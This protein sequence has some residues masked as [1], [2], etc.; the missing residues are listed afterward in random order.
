MRPLLLALP[1]ALLPL[2]LAQAHQHAH[3]HDHTHAHNHEH[4]SLGTHEH[5]TAELNVVLDGQTLEI[6]L[7]SP[8]MNLLGFEHAAKSA[9][10]RA[11]VSALQHQLQAPQTLL[12]LS[13][14][15]CSL[16][17]HTLESPLLAAEQ[18][19]NPHDQKHQHGDAEAAH[20]HDVEHSDI[21]AHYQFD[22]QQPDALKQLDLSELFKAFP[23]MEKIQVQLIGPAGQQ[24][25]ELGQGKTT[26]SF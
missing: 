18:A 14:G 13:S 20:D 2:T 16:V 21:H 25:L 3:K 23:G 17:S 26:L 15:D 1:F 24:G 22:C 8:A 6:A 4:G 12:S 7:K 9:A 11:K 5:G 19:H 10:D